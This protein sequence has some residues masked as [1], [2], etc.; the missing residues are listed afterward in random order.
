MNPF[1][2]FESP[3][4]YKVVMLYFSRSRGLAIVGRHAA[5]DRVEVIQLSGE[6][7]PQ[8]GNFVAL[9]YTGLT[10][11]EESPVITKSDFEKLVVFIEAKIDDQTRMSV[12]E[13]EA[14]RSL[15]SRST[16]SEPSNYIQ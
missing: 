15:R 2:L 7:D 11:N 16:S 1:E 12:V 5:A 3:E 9:D 4:V 13:P 6:V 10:R 14:I 8:T